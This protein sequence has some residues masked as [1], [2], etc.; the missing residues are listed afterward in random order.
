MII[1][2]NLQVHVNIVVVVGTIEWLIMVMANRPIASS[3]AYYDSPIFMANQ[4]DIA[5]HL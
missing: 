3:V 1:D 2:N 4:H 5:I